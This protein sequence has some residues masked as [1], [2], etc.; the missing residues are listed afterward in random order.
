MASRLTGATPDVQEWRDYRTKCHKLD[1]IRVSPRGQKSFCSPAL[2][3]PHFPSFAHLLHFWPL[4]SFP[5]LHLPPRVSS[6]KPI[7]HLSLANPR[8]CCS[9]SSQSIVAVP[10]GQCSTTRHQS[11]QG[12]PP[13]PLPLWRAVPCQH[14]QPNPAPAFTSSLYSPFF[15]ISAPQETRGE[16]HQFAFGVRSRAHSSFCNCRPLS[17]TEALPQS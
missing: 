11:Q 14:S 6:H 12:Q 15:F 17:R 1:H 2:F 4:F 13:P 7:A 10:H 16:S 3:V 8:P 9:F 5:L